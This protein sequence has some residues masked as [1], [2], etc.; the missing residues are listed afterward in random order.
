MAYPYLNY[1]KNGGSPDPQS[2]GPSE[3]RGDLACSALS[4]H[5]YE[6]SVQPTCLTVLATP[7]EVNG[8][9]LAWEA[10]SKFTVVKGQ[11]FG[12]PLRILL[13]LLVPY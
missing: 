1:L 12:R 2:C 4:V 10:T 9:S 3:Q 6:S 13:S 8:E 11:G 7:I 5:F